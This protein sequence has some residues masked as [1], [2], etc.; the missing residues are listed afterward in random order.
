M[1]RNGFMKYWTRTTAVI[2]LV[3]GVVMAVVGFVS[4]ALAPADAN[5]TY[6]FLAGAV[7]GLGAVAIV[8]S[9]VWFIRSRGM[10]SEEAKAHFKQLY[11]ERYHAAFGKATEISSFVM[12]VF[13][14]VCAVVF[15]LQD[16]QLVGW[17][18][19]GGAYLLVLLRS[20]L[21]RILLRLS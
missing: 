6:L 20:V 17:L 1:I 11:D 16:Q 14:L 9:V 21:T 18:F 3:V 2:V 12:V 10:T 19:M 5:N 8:L 13:L 7:L 4:A 15:L